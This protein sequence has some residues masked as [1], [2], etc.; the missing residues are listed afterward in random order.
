M[1]GFRADLPGQL[2]I[3]TGAHDPMTL[4]GSVTVPVCKMIGDIKAAVFPDREIKMLAVKDGK[5]DVRVV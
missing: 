5:R 4:S 3:G 1:F 2:P